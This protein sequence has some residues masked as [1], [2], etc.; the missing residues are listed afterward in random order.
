[1]IPYITYLERNNFE[2]ILVFL[3]WFLLGFIAPVALFDLFKILCILFDASK[4]FKL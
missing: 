1:M 4:M 2:V 3:K